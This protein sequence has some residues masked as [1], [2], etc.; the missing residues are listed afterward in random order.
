[1]ATLTSNGLRTPLRGHQTLAVDACI[2]EFTDGAPRVSVIMATG[3]G[4]TLVAL[5]TVQET[6]P[7]GNA[8]VVMPTLD[9]LEQTAA[10]WQGEGRQGVYL[11]YCS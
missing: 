1:M 10:V 8:L 9:L 5:N 2:D 4:K 6:A 7:Q 3:T 11:G